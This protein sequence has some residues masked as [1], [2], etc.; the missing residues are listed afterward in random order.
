MNNH[1]VQLRVAQYYKVVDL[2]GI[3]I[4]ENTY[5][6]LQIGVNDVWTD[7]PTVYIEE[8]PEENVRD[9]T[10]VVEFRPK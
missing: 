7:V 8:Q 6:K 5:Y 4:K 2:G 9:D 10:N 3:L 1:L